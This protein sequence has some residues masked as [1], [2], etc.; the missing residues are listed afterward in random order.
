MKR[1]N[2]SL[3]S[4]INR[5]ALNFKKRAPLWS[6]G[7]RCVSRSQFARSIRLR[8]A[9]SDRCWRAMLPRSAHLENATSSHL[10]ATRSRLD[11]ST[12][13]PCAERDAATPLSTPLAIPPCPLGVLTPRQAWPPWRICCDKRPEDETRQFGHE[14]GAGVLQSSP[15]RWARGAWLSEGVVL[16]APLPRKRVECGVW[17]GL[18]R[19]VQ[20]VANRHLATIGHVCAHEIPC[21]QRP[22]SRALPKATRPGL[23]ANHRRPSRSACYTKSGTWN[24][25][26]LLRRGALCRCDATTSLAFL[27]QGHP[28][29]ESYSVSGCTQHEICVLPHEEESNLHPHL[30]QFA[31]QA[32]G[33]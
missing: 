12:D 20:N 24:R 1:G 29:T 14:F 26:D 32:K 19:Y 7:W 5:W 33:G 2:T 23:Q 11:P 16:P 4:W 13:P 10:G 27:C 28:G 22:Y 31:C 21:L 9:L 3:R 17:Q 6:I 30:P 25:Q 8:T 15:R 18:K